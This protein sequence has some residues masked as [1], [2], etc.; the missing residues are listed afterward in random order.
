MKGFAA[1]DLEWVSCPVCDEDRARSL[2]QK[3][4]LNVVGCGNCLVQYVN[5]RPTAGRLAALYQEEY[6]TDGSPDSSG[7]QHVQ[8]GEMKLATARLRLALLHAHRSKGR[9]LDVGCGGG[10]FVQAAGAAGW[11]AV[12]LEPSVVAARRGGREQR[13]RIVAGRLEQAPFHAARF[14]AVTM[15]DVLEHVLSPRT[16]L[17]QARR[18]LVPG[19]LVLVET[20]NMAGWLTGLMGSRHPHVRPLEHL[21]YFTPETLR[22]LLE[23]CGYAVRHLAGSAP[24]VLTLDYILSLTPGTNPVL[25]ALVKGAVGWWG[26]LRRH[27]FQ[28]PLDTLVAVAEAPGERCETE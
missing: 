17:L 4:G 7:A 23:R 18:L 13:V 25:T 26:G 21:T 3:Q 9:V 5:P 14:D 12:G 11:S 8:H 22:F 19:G 10:F 16:F 15:L 27:R 24:K 6:F 2:F 1:T 20:P 28:V